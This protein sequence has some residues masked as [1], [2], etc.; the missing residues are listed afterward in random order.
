MDLSLIIA[1]SNHAKWL[2]NTQPSVELS[3]GHT[4]T[5][6]RQQSRIA[7]SNQGNNPSSQK[8]VHSISVQECCRMLWRSNFPQMSWRFP[9]HEMHREHTKTQTHTRAKLYTVQLNCD[10]RGSEHRS[11]A[12][13]APQQR[14]LTRI[15]STTDPQRS[16]NMPTGTGRTAWCALWLSQRSFLQLKRAYV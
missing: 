1:E 10:A 15:Q 2:R 9:H 6:S 8:Q 13:P 12:A 5:N 11:R 3:I 7:Y 16:F 4:N 14:S